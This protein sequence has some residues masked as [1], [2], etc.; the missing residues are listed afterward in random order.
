MANDN[1]KV[2]KVVTSGN[3]TK[4]HQF[5]NIS[6]GHQLLNQKQ[7]WSATNHDGKQFGSC[8]QVQ[9]GRQ[10]ETKGHQLISNKPTIAVTSTTQRPAAPKPIKKD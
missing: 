3:I 9:G 5:Q 10:P 8:V 2:E 4:G 6:E 1:N 7:T